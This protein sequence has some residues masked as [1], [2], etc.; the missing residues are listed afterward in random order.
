MNI[1]QSVCLQVCFVCTVFIHSGEF[2]MSLYSCAQDQ[3]LIILSRS[4]SDCRQSFGLDIGFIDHLHTQLGTTSNYSAI[5]NLHNLKATTAHTK[6][7]PAYCVFISRFLVTA[8]NSEDS[9]ASMLKS[10]LPIDLYFHR[11]PYRTDLVAPAVFHI[12][13]WHCPHRQHTVHSSMLF[14]L[15]HVYRSV[16]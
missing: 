5:A 2:S 13:P 8:S 6:S 14:P 1:F 15:E 11:L 4:M 7:F 16:P 3:I 10:S 9:S 12:T